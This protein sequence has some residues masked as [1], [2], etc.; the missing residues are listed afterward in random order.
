MPKNK[1]EGKYSIFNRSKITYIECF[2]EIDP[3]KK[4]MTLIHTI[5]LVF[6]IIK[7]AIHDLLL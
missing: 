3:F 1:N 6:I 7:K 5:T 4:H 2:P